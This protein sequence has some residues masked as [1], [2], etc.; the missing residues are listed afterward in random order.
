MLAEPVWLTIVNG[1]GMIAGIGG[2]ILLLMR[3]SSPRPCWRARPAVHTH[4]YRQFH[5]RLFRRAGD[6][7][8][9]HYDAGGGDFGWTVLA[10]TMGGA[11]GVSVVTRDKPD[12]A[13]APQGRLRI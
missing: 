8:C 9:C 6:G 1:L 3:Q 10:G 11:D 4:L 13:D 2:C 7:L 5:R 12:H